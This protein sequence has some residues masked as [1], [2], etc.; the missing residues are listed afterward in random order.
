M[1]TNAELAKLIRHT[2]WLAGLVRTA[3]GC[4]ST[5]GEILNRSVDPQ[6]TFEYHDPNGDV[7][8]VN[9]KV[10]EKRGS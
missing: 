5:D 3:G 9:L 4:T 8:E 7:V 6:G 10:L 1:P 2:D